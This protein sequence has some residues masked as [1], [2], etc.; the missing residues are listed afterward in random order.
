MKLIAATLAAA[1]VLRGNK[2]DYPCGDGTKTAGF[3]QYRDRVVS[4]TCALVTASPFCGDKTGV[5][6]LLNEFYSAG[7]A[8][9]TAAPADLCEKCVSSKAM[10]A[11]LGKTYFPFEL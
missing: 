3:T 11:G 8:G 9:I 1:S 5:T 10:A 6:C 4:G 7:C 2:I